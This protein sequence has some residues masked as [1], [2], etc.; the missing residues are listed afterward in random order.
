[1]AA[2]RRHADGRGRQSARPTFSPA[3]SPTCRSSTCSTPCSTTRLP[4]TPPEWQEWGNPIAD[5]EA[6]KRSVGYS[7]LRQCAA[8]ALSG[9]PGARRPDRSAR[10]LLGAGEMGREAARHHDRRRPGSVEDQHGCR[11]WR[12]G[13]AV[14]PAEGIALQQAFALWCVGMADSAARQGEDQGLAVRAA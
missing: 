2:G 13:R 14:R 12:R 3:S 11:S 5:A 9:D 10:D 6:F 4:L 1:M 8:A 7:A